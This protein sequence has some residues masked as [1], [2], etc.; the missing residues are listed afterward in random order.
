MSAL[1]FGGGSSVTAASFLLG[2]VGVLFAV[3]NWIPHALIMHEISSLRQR[4]E[5]GGQGI[6]STSGGQDDTATLVA[7]HN[8]AICIPQ[9]IAAGAVAV[10][11][12]VLSSPD[13][14]EDQVSW[15]FL[16]TVPAALVG[17]WASRS[18]NLLD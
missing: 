6:Q 18:S 5:D 12:V 2:S 8:M 16:L 10:L 9:I 15:A 17:V 1:S 13:N 7:I 11:F 14:K 3:S 4:P